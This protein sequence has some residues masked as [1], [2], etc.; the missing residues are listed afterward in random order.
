MPVITI[1]RGSYSHGVE[2]AEKVAQKLGYECISREVLIEASHDFNIPE[3]KL[4]QAIHDAPTLLD[5]IFSRK[6]KYL[7]YIQAAILRHLRR[8]NVVYHGFAGH[9][10]VKDISHALKVRIIAGIE[11][12]IRVLM[13]RRGMAR[14]EAVH[15]IHKLDEHRRKW[16]QQLYGVATS[17]P[18]LYDMV[19][20]IERITIDDAV[21]IICHKIGLQ[22]FRT[23]AQSQQ[24]IENL[25]L[26]A[27]VK[28]ALMDIQPGIR[29][30]AE[31][32]NVR[33]L[34]SLSAGHKAQ[35]EDEIK[36]LTE[37]I[38]ELKSVSM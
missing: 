16:S 32:G 13:E 18:S 19:L 38:P 36:K 31:N 12:R 23:T 7:A 14:K 4:F 1:S 5:N 29:V 37:K 34:T 10:F 24:K 27:E 9:F 21:Y 2:V 28:A 22:H 35:F 33:L 15:Y 8:D 6:E 25:W 3:I 30:T 11:E 17:E 20:N 26:A